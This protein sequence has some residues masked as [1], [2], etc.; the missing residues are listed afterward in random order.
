MC[1]VRVYGYMTHQIIIFC[2]IIYVDCLYI[3]VS[4]SDHHDVA[5]KVLL[6]QG[7]AAGTLPLTTVK[8]MQDRLLTRT[9]NLP[10]EFLPL[11]TLFW[12]TRSVPTLSQ[13]AR[14]EIRRKM[15]E[16]GKFSRENLK[17]LEL[18][19]AMIDFM[20]LKDLGD[21]KEVE[22][23]MENFSSLLIALM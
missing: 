23:I 10:D 2:D 13:L 6:F 20:Q 8:D 12:M 1:Y 22:S 4:V 17:T 7:M 3:C 15:A 5:M 11:K 21:G 14:S 19:V 9:R 16:C 18:P